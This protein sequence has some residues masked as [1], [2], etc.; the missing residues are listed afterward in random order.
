[1]ID[2]RAYTELLCIINSMSYRNRKKIPDEIMNLIKSKINKNYIFK[3]E[4]GIKNTPLLEDTR[5]L[6]SVIYTDYFSTNEEKRVILAKEKILK[7][8]AT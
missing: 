8:K 2:S 5:K 3:L 6:L 1:M 4:K 7:S